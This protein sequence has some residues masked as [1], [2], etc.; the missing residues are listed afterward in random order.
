MSDLMLKEFLISLQERETDT[1]E[2][3]GMNLQ[4]FV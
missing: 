4:G 2:G 3:D 1:E